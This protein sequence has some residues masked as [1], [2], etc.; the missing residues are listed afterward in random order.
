MANKSLLQ[1]AQ[2]AISKRVLCGEAPIAVTEITDRCLYSVFYGTLDSLRIE[3]LINSIRKFHNHND[4]NMMIIELSHVET[5]DDAIAASLKKLHKSLDRI[6]IELVYCGIKPV[7]A[8]SISSVEI[9]LHDITI[10]KDLKHAI[11]VIYEKQGLKLVP[12]E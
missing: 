7:V 12:I 8:A 1:E 11:T 4:H 3:N 9:A 10:E 6:G 5:I 2:V